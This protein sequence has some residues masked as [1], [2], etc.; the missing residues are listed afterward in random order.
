MSITFAPEMAPVIGFRL[1]DH[2]GG[3]SGLIADHVDATAQLVALN[4]S[5]DVL[6]GCTDPESARYYGAGIESVTADGDDAPEVNM[7]NTNAVMLLDLLGLD[8]EG[9]GDCPADDFLGRVLVASALSPAD[10]GVPAHAVGGNPRMID[11][12]R[13]PGYIQERLGDLHRLA[14]WAVENGRTV[15][16]G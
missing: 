5:G 14:A 8:T 10:E 11:C 4:A 3:R 2:L 15:Q 1:T 12:G 13:R 16:W 9:F 6:P 7:S